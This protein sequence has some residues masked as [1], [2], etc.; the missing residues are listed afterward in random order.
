MS[1]TPTNQ[2]TSLYRYF[3]AEAALLTIENQNLRIGRLKEMNDLFEW[4]PGITGLEDSEKAAK[5]REECI[6]DWINNQHPKTGFI[7]FS[8]VAEEPLMWAHYA[9][10]HTGVCLEFDPEVFQRRVIIDYNKPR[11]LFDAN[12]HGDKTY[13]LGFLELLYSIKSPNWAYEKEVR[14]HFHLKECDAA[15]GSYFVDMPQGVLRKVILG[16]NCKLEEDYVRRIL[17]Q[18][19]FEAT[20][21]RARLCHQEYKVLVD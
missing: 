2:S 7:S 8:Q 19:G 10:K 17:Q 12:Q 5:T 14:A 15:N 16:Y 21:T 20:V 3:T 1:T 6:E 4:R 18:S 11:P 13:G 9:E